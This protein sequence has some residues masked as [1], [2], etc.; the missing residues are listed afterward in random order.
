MWK[1]VILA[2]AMALTGCGGGASSGNITTSGVVTA[3]SVSTPYPFIP[4]LTTAQLGAPGVQYVILSGWYVGALTPPPVKIFQ[5]N[6]DGTVAD[7]TKSVLGADFAISVNYTLTSDFNSDGID[8]IFFP[9]FTDSPGTPNNPSVVFLSR[10][11]QSHQRVDLP[12]Q[13]WAHA[14]SVIDLDQNGTMDVLTNNGVYWLN[15]GHGN[16]TYGQFTSAEGG[17]GVCGGDLFRDGHVQLVWTDGYQS[18]QDSIIYEIGNFWGSNFMTNEVSRLPVPFFDRSSAVE[19]SHDVAC[20]VKDINNDGWNDVIVVSAL[21]SVAARNGTVSHQSR[22][23]VYINQGNGTF[24]D[25]TDTALIGYNANVLSS[26]T[27]KFIDAN[28]D[29]RPDLWLMDWDNQGVSANQIWINQGDGTFRQQRQSD[30][31]KLLTDYSKA[32][33]G[34][35]TNMGIM[36]PVNTA[37]GWNFAFTSTNANTMYLGYA[38]TQWRF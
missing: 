24:T 25:L 29:G 15:D 6:A 21:D 13:G 3:T 11:G 8:D 5:A 1:L 7:A 26:Y 9:G 28:R 23:Q 10:P 14:S 12:D 36:I 27:P 34:N 32:T 16:F 38:N 18:K 35:S 2:T 20:S 37:L 33:G 4:S 19:E 31:E 30:I 22:V 17:S